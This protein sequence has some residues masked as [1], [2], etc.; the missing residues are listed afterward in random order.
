MLLRDSDK[1]LSLDIPKRLKLS[2]E[3]SAI[4]TAVASSPLPKRAD[5]ASIRTYASG[6]TGKITPKFAYFIL[7]AASAR[8]ERLISGESA[9]AAAENLYR[10]AELC[11]PMSV[12]E[13]AV[14]GRDL[15]DAGVPAGARVGEVLSELLASVLANPDFNTRENLLSLVSDMM[16]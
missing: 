10:S 14:C 15:L 3:L 1:A 12:S 2:G 4:V 13:L 8:G 5:S 7:L 6:I 11:E 9:T 16:R